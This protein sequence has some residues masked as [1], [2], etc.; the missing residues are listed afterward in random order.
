MAPRAAA[1]HIN[2]QLPSPPTIILDAAG[3][4]SS[5]ETALRTC[6]INGTIVLI[7]VPPPNLSSF[8]VGALL[9]KELD[10][11]GSYCY[12]GH[13][14]DY[15]R[16]F[17]MINE[18]KVDVRPLITDLVGLEDVDAAF[19]KSAAGGDTIKVRKETLQCLGDGS[20]VGNRIGLTSCFALFGLVIVWVMSQVMFKMP[21][22]QSPPSL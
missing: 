8:L 6:A 13:G 16:A 21:E 1:T 7:G 2:S 5:I 18:R 15:P 12:G 11:K 14:T 20:V 3:F 22:V 4:P 9:D 19:R 10:F 17:E